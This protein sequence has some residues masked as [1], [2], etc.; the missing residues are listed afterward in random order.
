MKS[1]PPPR[2][3]HSNVYDHVIPPSPVVAT[4]MTTI[5]QPKPTKSQHAPRTQP[6]HH[7]PPHQRAAAVASAS[8]PPR[9][10]H[11][12]SQ[13]PPSSNREIP[14]AAGAAGDRESP[15]RPV[16]S[17]GSG[18]FRIHRWQNATAQSALP[19]SL[20]SKYFISRVPFSKY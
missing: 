4:V 16:A 10:V 7:T 20:R 6:V 17:F 13:V 1:E 19:E 15:P 12:H 9:P 8:P 11:Q 5:K 2:S 14:R 18:P 3:A